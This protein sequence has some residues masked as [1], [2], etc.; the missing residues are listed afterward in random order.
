M[1]ELK[2]PKDRTFW[3]AYSDDGKVIHYGVTEPDQVTTTGQ[4]NFKIS[5]NVKDIEKIL[6]EELKVSAEELADKHIDIKSS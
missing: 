5:T 4:P 1:A 3:T 6:K 2:F